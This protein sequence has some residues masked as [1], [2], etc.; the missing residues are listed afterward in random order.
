MLHTILS[1]QLGKAL[2]SE[3]GAFLYA[4]CAIIPEEIHSNLQ[5]VPI[6]DSSVHLVHNQVHLSLKARCI[7]R[8][9]CSNYQVAIFLFSRWKCRK[10]K[11]FRVLFYYFSHKFL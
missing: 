7:S 4:K 8:C 11:A 5:S 10:Y 6:V 2:S 9:I 3:L 1:V